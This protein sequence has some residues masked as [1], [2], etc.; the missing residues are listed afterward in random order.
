MYGEELF[1]R[2]RF[3]R[4]G[5]ISCVW[6]TTRQ[7]CLSSCQPGHPFTEREGKAVYA[8]DGHDVLC[9]MALIDLRGLVPSSHEDAD[10]RM[11]QYAADEV[12]EIAGT[13]S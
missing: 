13:Y 11:F 12:Q 8:T 2:Q 5:W 3:Q 10:T 1:P 9:S 6:T 7:N 4:T